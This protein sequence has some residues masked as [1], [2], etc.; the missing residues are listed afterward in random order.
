[1]NRNKYKNY[2]LS[3]LS[4]EQIILK[5]YYKIVKRFY[6]I[7]NSIFY[8]I[9][10]TVFQFTQRA[11]LGTRAIGLPTPVVEDSD[12][13]MKMKLRFEVSFLENDV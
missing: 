4:S 10:I 7:K 11:T 2:V 12:L 5:F 1:M 6:R 8:E 13:N 3:N 9:T